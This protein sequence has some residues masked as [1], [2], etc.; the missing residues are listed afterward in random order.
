MNRFEHAVGTAFLAQS[1]VKLHGLRG[2]EAKAF[3]IA[4]LLH[5]AV[6]APFGHSLEYLF[7]TLKNKEYEHANMFKM[8]FTGRTVPFSRN[9]YFGGKIAL[10]RVVKP[11]M[12]KC[13]ISILDGTHETSVLLNHDIDID[14]IDNVFRFAYHIGIDFDRSV[15]LRL[16]MMLRYKEGVLVINDDSLPMFREWFR[17]RESLYVRLLEDPGDFAAKALLERCFIEAVT[18][19]T[20]SETDWVMTDDQIVNEIFKRGN[21]VARKC[22]QRLMLMDF[23]AHSFIAFSC[24]HKK[25][26]GVLSRR[27]IDLINLAF[28][29][30]V[31]LHFI[32]DVNKT[33]RVIIGKGSD[34]ADEK[35]RIG[36]GHDR[37]LIGFF[38]DSMT[39]IENLRLAIEEELDVRLFDL[40]EDHG[41]PK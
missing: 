28:K 7:E 38:S 20:I 41:Q 30:N 17:V 39:N 12:L 10:S 14:N 16:S 26:S 24:E 19:S 37:Y 13:I 31:L 15:P 33:R 2:E 6:T 36:T 22:I 5:D 32:K 40:N 25:I 21:Q 29:Q 4:A 34:R 23:P 11:D 3:V 27:K 9:I 18:S 35:V 1:I 8:F